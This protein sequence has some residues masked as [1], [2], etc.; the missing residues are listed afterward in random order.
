MQPTIVSEPASLADSAYEFINSTDTESQDG[1]L[2]ESTSSLS[3]PRPDDVHSLNGSVN[4]YDTDSDDDQEDEEEEQEEEEED[5][6]EDEDSV[7]SSHASSIRYADE[8]L[9]N[10]SSQ[11]QTANLGYGSSS[12]GS[13]IVV[14]QEDK[15]DPVLLEKISVNHAIKE[16]DEEESATVAKQLGLPNTPKRMVA[17]IRQTMSQ[18]YLST[19][20]PFRILFVGHPGAQRSIV[21]KLSGALWASPKNGDK[22]QDYFNRHREGV[23]NIVPISSFGPAPE[24]DLMEASHYQIKIEH[25][26]SAVQDQSGSSS[27]Y[28]LTIEHDKVYQSH[29]SSSGR[30]VVNP[31]WTLPH[32]AVFYCADNDDAEAES[33][34]AAAWACMKG[35]S[36]PCIF[37]SER[38]DFKQRHGGD[39]AEYV[40][41]HA[42]HLC[43]ESRDLERPMTP[44]RFPIDL[45]SFETIDARQM[46]RNLAYLTG[47]TEPEESFV[48]VEMV[49]AEKATE[50]EL[51]EYLGATRQAW[52]RF[53]ETRDFAWAVHLLVA[54]CLSFLIIPIAS[55]WNSYSGSLSALYPVP[56]VGQ[57]SPSAQIGS[58]NSVISE[59]STKTPTATSTTTKT[60]II[61]LTST[62][63]VQLSQS[64]PSTSTLAS[65]LSYAGLLSDKPSAALP[66]TELKKPINPPTKKTVCSV[67]TSGS[68]EIVVDLVGRNKAWWFAADEVNIEVHRGDELISTKTSPIDGGVLVQLEPKD[69]YGVLQVS[70]VSTGRPKINETFEVDFGKTAVAEVLEAGLHI[71]QDVFKK[72]SSGVDEVATHIAEDTRGVA[73]ALEHAR[74]RGQ[75]AG[76]QAIGAVSRATHSTKE[77]IARGI[78]NSAK[79]AE[80]MGDQLNIAILQAQIASRLWWLKLQG[81]MEE[82]AQYQRNASVFLKMKIAQA[83]KAKTLREKSKS[84]LSSG[85]KGR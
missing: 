6:D 77:N 63:T 66:E 75:A 67:R 56:A 51:V 43:L 57:T 83:A 59:I 69:A 33:T 76:S 62:Q 45:A 42:V 49:P 82:H 48:E 72:V 44:R 81:R 80:D 7:Q 64:G 78:A 9:Q 19:H 29:I 36:V 53:V 3:A 11:A 46:N 13:G 16:C 47:L 14:F 74:E 17:S 58:L 65:A 61:N 35:H 18:K 27:L 50:F 25:C 5:E 84:G 23:Y 39:W 68:N 8:A 12:E 24:L 21:L 71:L 26:T 40:D 37:I 31:K 38:Q 34:R 55:M 30:P 70:V 79:A 73:D 4:H 52:A 2:S 32:I 85:R 54:L 28:T 10:P 22:E 15:D 41:E 20:E 1:R 60:V